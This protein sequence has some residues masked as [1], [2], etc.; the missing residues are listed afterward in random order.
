MNN[1]TNFFQ[2]LVKKIGS[3]ERGQQT[4]FRE[5]KI[6]SNKVTRLEANQNW[7][8]TIM[9]GFLAIVSKLL[10]WNK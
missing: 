5:N 6:L 7:H 2:Y 10:F 4:Y 1:E 9:I 3:L 8:R